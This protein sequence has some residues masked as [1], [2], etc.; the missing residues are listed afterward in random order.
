MFSPYQQFATLNSRDILTFEFSW[1]LTSV[2]FLKK[3]AKPFSWLLQFLFVVTFS[4][5]KNA[6]REKLCFT[7]FNTKIYWNKSLTASVLFYIFTQSVNSY[8]FHCHILKGAEVWKIWFIKSTE[9]ERMLL[10]A[11]FMPKFELVFVLTQ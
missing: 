7:H 3:F 5:F 2:T 9:N 10:S 4:S 11:S 8:T 6:H 1:Y